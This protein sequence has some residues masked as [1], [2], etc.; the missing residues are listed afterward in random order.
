MINSKRTV[1]VTGAA[2]GIGYAFAE[3]LAADGWNVAILD[4]HGA[5]QAAEKIVNAGGKA[6]GYDGNVV[7]PSDWDAMLDDLVSKGSEIHG[8]VNNAAL[9]SSLEMQEF[10]QTDHD[11]WMRVMEVNTW[12][13]FLASQKVYPFFKLGGGGVI[14]NVA[15]TSPMKGVTGMPHYVA[16][17]GAVIALTK[18]LAKELGADNVRVNAIAPGFTLSDGIMRNVEHVEKFREIGKSSRSLKRDQQ[19]VD[20]VG[21]VSFLLGDDSSF[22]TGQTI[23]V[24]GGAYFL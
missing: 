9:F 24:D 14:V 17:K 21:A 1:I 3:R 13:P 18:S 4:M 8:L 6:Y 2:Q 11:T 12:G 16:S 20:L 5:D 23:V 10:D 22:I 19:P 7:S 15:S